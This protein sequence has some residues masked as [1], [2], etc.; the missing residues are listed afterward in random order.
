MA[1]PADYLVSTSGQM[2][3]PA[4][5]RHRWGLDKGGRIVVIDLGKPWSFFRP[6][7]ERCSLPR[8]FQQTTISGLFGSSATQTWRPRRWP[9]SSSTTICFETFSPLKG[10]RTLTASRRMEWLPPACGFSGYALRSKGRQ[11]W[12]SSPPP[13]RPSRRTYRPDFDRS[14]RLSRKTLRSCPCANWHGAWQI[15]RPATDSKDEASRLPWSKRWQPLIGSTRAL[16]C[17]PTMLDPTFERRPRRWRPVPHPLG[18]RVPSHQGPG[19]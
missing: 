17:Q 6:V 11:L 2:S 1:V 8:P 10:P 16:P 14:W 19:C 5:I 9:P 15:S 4:E 18:Q 7:G 12:A 13:W 3:V